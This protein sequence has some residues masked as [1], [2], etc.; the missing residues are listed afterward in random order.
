M[1]LLCS[2]I[3]I[4]GHYNRGYRYICVTRALL[5]KYANRGGAIKW[6][7]RKGKLL[8]GDSHHKCVRWH[9]GLLGGAVSRGD[10]WNSGVPT[11]SVQTGARLYMIR[12]NRSAESI[13]QKPYTNTQ[14][15]WYV[16]NQPKDKYVRVTLTRSYRFP[17]RVACLQRTC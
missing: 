7:E 5:D 2:H 15:Q 6:R 13:V 1:P 10:P 8:C 9:K 16:A 17:H 14:N 4:F 11:N 3:I 12:Q